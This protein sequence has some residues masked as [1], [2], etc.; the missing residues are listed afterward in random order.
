MRWED[1]RIGDTII[2][3]WVGGEPY[4]SK[5]YDKHDIAEEM[6]YM[7]NGRPHE[8]EVSSLCAEANSIEL[9]NWDV[10]GEEWTI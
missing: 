5:T 2:V 3:R 1:V 7:F 8:V 9:I 10:D 4:Y 6:E